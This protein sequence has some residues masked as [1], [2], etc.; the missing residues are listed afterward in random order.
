MKQGYTLRTRLTHAALAL[1]VLLPAGRAAA[2]TVISELLYDVPGTDTGQV[3]V[4]LFGTPGTLLDDMWLEGINGT[5]GS[6]YQTVPLTGTIPSDGVFVIGDDDGTGGTQVGNADLVRNV[7]FQN[8]PDSV[9]LRDSTGVLDAVGYGDFSGAV[10]AGEGNA[11]PDVPAGWSLA[12]ANP[13][14]DSNDNRADFSGLEVPTPGLAPASTVPV[15]PALGLL[16][17]GLV[18][19]AGIARRRM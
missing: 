6:V 18:G 7:D 11:V 16:V 10:F 2:A 5:N 8:G 19:L 14:L 1:A 4:E 17:S 15:P 13:A 12:R 3:F 9:V